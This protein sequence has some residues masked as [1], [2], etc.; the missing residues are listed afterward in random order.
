MGRTEARKENVCRSDLIFVEKTTGRGAPTW[1]LHTCQAHSAK[2]YVEAT[3]SPNHLFA[4]PDRCLSPDSEAA[5]AIIRQS[6]YE[7]R[8]R[9]DL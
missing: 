9:T 8:A 4:L 5:D 7:Q 2:H 3:S 6:T 1:S